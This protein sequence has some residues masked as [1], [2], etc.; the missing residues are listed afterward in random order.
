MSDLEMPGERPPGSPG[1]R[2]LLGL[3][4]LVGLLL[5]LGLVVKLAGWH[6]HA[7]L[8]QVVEALD[9][10]DPGWRLEDIERLRETPPPEQNSARVVVNV[11]RAIPKDWNKVEQVLDEKIRQRGVPPPVR[12]DGEQEATLKHA[13]HR[14]APALAEARKLAAL[15]RGRH[16]LTF[17]VNPISFFLTDQQ[18]T[19]R[20]AS[21]LQ[22]D[23]HLRAQNQDLHGALRSCRGILN[24]ARSLDDE[25]TFLSQLIRIAIVA[26]ACGTAERVLAQGEAADEDLAGLQQ[27]LALEERHPTLRVAMRG[28]RA[29]LHDLFT[30]LENGTLKMTAVFGPGLAEMPRDV[31]WRRR[32]FGFTR[33]DIRHDHLL[34]LELMNE[35]LELIE[36]PAGE[37]PAAE[38]RLLARIKALPPDA[39]L[40][41]SV[42]P[43]L[44][45][46][47][48]PFRRKQAQV[49]SFLV[50]LAAERYRLKHGTWP[51]KLEDLKA[52]GL[53]EVPLDPYDGKPIR[54]R[55]LADGVVAYS[56]G[57]DRR[58][59]GGQVGR[60]P[61]GTLPVD[62]GYRLWDVTARH[63]PTPAAPGE[64]KERP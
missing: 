6:G 3:G 42:V 57:K 4:I 16:R 2:I 5:L 48:D 41:R 36:R 55:R 14:A 9:E 44:G 51:D 1:R 40:A 20:C 50:L 18:E 30:K 12:F 52:S 59:D 21:L 39:I 60:Y 22:L 19:R 8:E 27:L 32:L 61:P 13:L 15:P 31:S 47:T 35:H 24:A 43:G 23:A 62:E 17:D 38:A 10:S 56:V 25:P 46:I 63:Q 64:K 37:Q 26:V 49:R 34:A 33:G 58:D 7:R 11:S 28:E 53:K 29:I 54:Y 45:S